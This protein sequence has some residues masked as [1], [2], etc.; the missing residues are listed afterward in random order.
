MGVI[1]TLFSLKSYL[2]FPMLMLVLALIMGARL[3]KAVEG[4][5][6]IGVALVGISMIASFFLEA[7]APVASGVAAAVGKSSAI[8]DV[9]WPMMAMLVWTMDVIY[10]IIPVHI[11]VNII[12]LIFKWTDT[13][14]I[15]IWN[16]WHIAIASF[17]V[18]SATQSIFLVLAADAIMSVISL[19]LCDWARPAV[20]KTINMKE[21]QCVSTA[22]SLFYMPFAIIING[23]CERVPGL[24]KLSINPGSL[25]GKWKVMLSPGFIAVP[26][27]MIFALCAG[28]SA[29]AAAEF[30]MKFSAVFLLLPR[31]LYFLKE[32][33]VPVANATEAFTRKRIAADRKVYIGVNQLVAADHPSIIISTII[34]IPITVLMAALIPFIRIFPMGDLMN[35]VSIIVVVAAVCKGNVFR[36]VLT[37]IPIVLLNLTLASTVAPAYTSAAAG[38]GY[39]I[40]GV[41]GEFAASFNGASYIN[42]WLSQVLKGEG[43]AL[44]AIPL[45]AAAIYICY[46]YYKKTYIK[47]Q[48]E[49]SKTII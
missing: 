35:V 49:N 38:L 40:P 13:I 27:G 17:L 28:Y 20:A 15:D 29:I 2:L 45:I 44:A 21:N 32:G 42:V 5:L 31:V 41:S 33:F 6:Y 3:L 10:W 25:E 16:Y 19:K 4:A 8:T 39:V 23:I 34:L 11:A 48:A 43:W 47:K 36:I 26:I 12:M 14:N 22:N 18:Y 30:T 1:Q 7:A 46:L 37:G 24:N 9:G